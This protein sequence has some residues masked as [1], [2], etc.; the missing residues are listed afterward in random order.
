LT[1]RRPR[2]T[3]I[4]EAL[5][6]YERGRQGPGQHT[7]AELLEAT[8]VSAIRIEMRDIYDETEQGYAEWRQT[9]E[10]DRYG[11]LWTEHFA[12]VRAAVARGV[13][14]QRVRIISE[15]VSEYIRWERACTSLNIEAGEDIR[16]L[17]R[18]KAGDLMLP[19]ADCWVFDNRLIR[20]NFQRGGIVLAAWQ[21][22]TRGPARL[23]TAPAEPI[24]PKRLAATS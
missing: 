12:M 7:F 3:L 17:P 5:E 8:Q 20:W 19:G 10:L 14:M 22:P 2:G 11:P 23:D 4:R 1:T 21:G 16:W 18:T 13:T 24:A 6:G 15:P 9:G